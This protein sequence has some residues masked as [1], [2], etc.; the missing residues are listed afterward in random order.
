MLPAPSRLS[1]PDV[2]NEINRTLSVPGGQVIKA[3]IMSCE[4][5]PF[6]V[7][8]VQGR[9]TKSINI[10]FPLVRPPKTRTKEILTV[11]DSTSMRRL[12]ALT[13]RAAGYDATEACSGMEAWQIAKTKQFD[14]VL[15]DVNMPEM[16]GITLIR[17]LRALPGYASI[18]MLMLTTAMSPQKKQEGKA[19]GA[20]GWI[21]KPFD[22]E[23][24]VSLIKRIL[25]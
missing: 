14:L 13:L 18:P 20:S 1:A 6:Q 7:S 2:V 9:E 23:Q 22:Q 17:S 12:V 24:L 8:L 4:G 15:A 11:D 3:V 21:V 19:A 10:E 25:G 16:D 5:E